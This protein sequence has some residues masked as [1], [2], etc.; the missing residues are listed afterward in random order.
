MSK[1]EKVEKY[2]AKGNEEKLLKLAGEKELDVRLA[3]IEGLGKIG[4]DNGFNTLIISLT[5]EE[6]AIRAASAKALGVMK[7]EHAKAHL[8]HRLELEK[9]ETVLQAI[10]GAIAELHKV[11]E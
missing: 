5:D 10:K 2:I 11:G 8:V 4:Q 6:P 3:V 9:D 1:L 7:N